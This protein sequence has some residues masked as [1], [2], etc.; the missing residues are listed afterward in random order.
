MVCFH[1]WTLLVQ[2]CIVPLQLQNG[3]NEQSLVG[4]FCQLHLYMQVYFQT[5]V[6]EFGWGV[7]LVFQLCLLLAVWI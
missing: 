4:K 7:F 6:K 2:I 5:E 3:F 1:N